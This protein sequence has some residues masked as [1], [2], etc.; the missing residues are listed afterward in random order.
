MP[1]ISPSLSPARYFTVA[2]RSVTVGTSGSPVDRANVAL[3]T[4]ITRWRPVSVT[5]RAV[6]AAGTLALGTI[7]VYTQAAAAGTTIVTAAAL[8]TLTVANVFVVS[9]VAAVTTGITDTNV[10]V[11]QTVNSANAGTID[12]FVEC[13]D[14]T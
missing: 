7:G 11:R 14:L 9:T 12:V 2:L 6:T 4:G 13:E 5:I 10:Y 1:N 3:P 8:T